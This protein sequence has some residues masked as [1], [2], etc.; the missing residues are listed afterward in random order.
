MKKLIDK[1]KNYHPNK[2]ESF[3]YFNI[4]LLLILVASI[5]YNDI[6]FILNHGK[7]IIEHGIPN[8]EPFSIHQNFSFMIQQP[9]TSIIYYLVYSMF[10]KNGLMTLISLTTGYIIFI[11]YKLCMLISD[12]RHNLS[13]MITTILTSFLTMFL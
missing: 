9:L 12:N 10:G 6:W 4:P 1:F 13:V 11:T 2:L 8:V 3:L 7:Y 5:D